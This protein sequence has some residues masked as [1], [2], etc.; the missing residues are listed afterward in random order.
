LIP[1]FVL[2]LK[3]AAKIMGW[4][5]TASCVRG[6]ILGKKRFTSIDCQRIIPPEIQAGQNPAGHHRLPCFSPAFQLF[7]LAASPANISVFY[8]CR[9]TGTSFDRQHYYFIQKTIVPYGQR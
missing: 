2:I 5:Q 8:I 7:L 1:V 4:L 6:N 3:W 9:L